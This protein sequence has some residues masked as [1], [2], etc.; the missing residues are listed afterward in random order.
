MAYIDLDGYKD[1]PKIEFI[2]ISL[3]A[4]YKKWQQKLE[5][6]NPRWKQYIIPENYESAFVK[7]YL[8]QYLQ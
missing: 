4:G 1:N 5:A 8:N 7:E 6:D 2:S 3:D